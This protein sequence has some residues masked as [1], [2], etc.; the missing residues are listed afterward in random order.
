MEVPTCGSHHG[1]HLAQYNTT[2]RSSNI[3]Q[4]RCIPCIGRYQ[5]YS[6]KRV[7]RTTRGTGMIHH[8]TTATILSAQKVALTVTE[9]KKQLINICEELQND[10]D[11]INSFSHEHTLLITGA[12]DPV[13]ITRGRVIPRPDIFT[14][15]EGADNIIIQQT[16]MAV[17]QGAECL[18]VT[19]DVYILLLHY[20]NQKELNIPMFMESPVHGRQTRL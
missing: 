17:Q 7:T 15:H 2:L 5:E 14:S 6:I 20:Y 11:F 3:T 12:G 18:F 9:N 4:A 16:F 1:Q 10:K 13:E 8:L 19:A